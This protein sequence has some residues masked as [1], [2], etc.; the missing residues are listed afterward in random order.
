LVQINAKRKGDTGKGWK[1][2]GEASWPSG[3]ADVVGGAKEN[4]L[5]HTGV[6]ESMGKTPES[7]FSQVGI[8]TTHKQG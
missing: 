1:G 6:Q 2:R 4:P 5:N 7:K 8:Q 3:E